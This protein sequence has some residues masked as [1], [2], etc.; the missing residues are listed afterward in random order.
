MV[1]ASLPYPAG[2]TIPAQNH[3][4]YLSMGDATAMATDLCKLERSSYPVLYVLWPFIEKQS[5]ST[6]LKL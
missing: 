2:I 6:F 4:V 1:T 5:F 3:A